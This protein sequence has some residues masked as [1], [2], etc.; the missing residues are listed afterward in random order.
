MQTVMDEFGRH[1]LLSFDR[2]PSTREQTIEIAHEA[3]LDGWSRL[4]GWVDEA[5]D[6]IRAQ[7][8]LAAAALEWESNGRDPS[9]LLRGAR[10][11]QT[12]AWGGGDDACDLKGGSDLPR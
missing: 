6:D 4:R 3:L 11:N 10:L 9:F 7:R 8:R 1:R 12:K 2:D 5:R